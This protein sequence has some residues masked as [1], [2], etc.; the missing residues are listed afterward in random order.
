LRKKVTMMRRVALLLT[1]TVMVMLLCLLTGCASGED[2]GGGQ[3]QASVDESSDQ[4]QRVEQQE[5]TV[6]SQ[7]RQP[8]QS[9]DLDE[10]WSSKLILQ[11][12]SGEIWAMNGQGSEALRLTE[13]GKSYQNPSLSP[14]GKKIAF[15][16]ERTEGGCGGASACASTSPE[17]TYAQIYVMNADGSDQ[18]QLVEELGVAS[19]PTW[20][21]DGTQIA[22]EGYGQDGWADIYFVDVS[23]EGATSRPRRL[24]VDD[25]LLEAT[26]PSWSPDGTEIAFA[27]LHSGYHAPGKGYHAIFEIDVNSLEEARLTKGSDTEYSPTWSPDGEK[28]AY[29][30]DTNDTSSIHVVGS[31]SSSP[32][33]LREFPFGRLGPDWRALP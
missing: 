32:T 12:G 16:S 3:Q 4:P 25:D 23:P 27:G 29:V 10:H 1:A 17:K 22:F 7:M 26:E 19:S 33:L 15:I 9:V 31:D 21:P 13:E 2:D 28:I 5:N 11:S 24:A 18:T 8:T 20:S 30:R 14:D 6:S